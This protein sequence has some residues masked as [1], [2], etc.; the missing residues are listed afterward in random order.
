MNVLTHEEPLKLR[1]CANVIARRPK[2]D[3]AI[4][5]FPCTPRRHSDR[6]SQ[7]QKGSSNTLRQTVEQRGRR[8]ASGLLAD[9]PVDQPCK[10]RPYSP[11]WRELP[12]TGDQAARIEDV[13]QPEQYRRDDDA[14]SPANSVELKRSSEGGVQS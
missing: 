7:A 13:H 3:E 9:E 11:P 10:E 2:A 4:S 8:D 1:I 14:P 5:H 6:P 12:V